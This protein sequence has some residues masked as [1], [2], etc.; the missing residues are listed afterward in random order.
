[1]SKY[2]L[3]DTENHFL[4]KE[5]LSKFTNITSISM[6]NFWKKQKKAVLSITMYCRKM[7]FGNSVNI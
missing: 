5:T 2:T 1:M 3:F 6:P 7:A 4:K